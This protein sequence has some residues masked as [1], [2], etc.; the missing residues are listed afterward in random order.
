[1]GTLF[2]KNTTAGAIHQK[3]AA[4]VLGEFAGSVMGE[5]GNFGTYGLEGFVNIPVTDALAV[6][7]SGMMDES[8][9]YMEDVITGENTAWSENQ[10]IRLQALYEFNDNISARLILD[11]SNTDDNSQRTTS[12]RRDNQPREGS[13]VVSV[14]PA[15]ALDTSTGGKGAWFWDNSDP[16]NP[17]PYDPFDYKSY[18]N[19]D[20]QRPLGLEQHGAT[21]HVDFALPNDIDVRSIT[22]YR[23]IA[24]G[25]GGDADWG[26]VAISGGFNQDYDFLTFSQEFIASGDFR[27]GSWLAGFNYFHEETEYVQ[28]TAGA[29]QLPLTYE[30]ILGGFNNVIPGIVDLDSLYIPF[31]PLQDSLL[32]Q[33]EDS[34]GVF[35]HVEFDL[36]DHLQLIGGVRYNDIQ[37]DSSHTNRIATGATREEQLDAMFDYVFDNIRLFYLISGQATPSPD[38]DASVDEGEATW[39]VALQWRPSDG[40]QLYGKYARGYKAGGTNFNVDAIGGAPSIAP[41]L[42]A[43]GIIRPGGPALVGGVRTFNPIDESGATYAPEF[44]DAYEIGGRWEYLAR[45]GRMSVTLFHSDFEDL[46]VATFDGRQFIVRNSGSARTR[47]VEFDNTFQVNDALQVLQ[48]VTYLD[49]EFGDDA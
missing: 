21:L 18:V 30:P 32:E 23:S 43:P 31:T 42:G 4:P 46:Q 33:D 14:F 44:V 35:G 11:Y 1:Q 6:R 26:P 5:A 40:V 28:A 2:G 3:T 38:W 36:T 16:A 49:A 39:D 29:T 22:G 48:A 19:L 12:V 37:K 13:A 15:F 41:L 9:G 8:D 34:I 47:G 24:S 25:A 27:L 20:V 10:A 17:G 7:L 45:R